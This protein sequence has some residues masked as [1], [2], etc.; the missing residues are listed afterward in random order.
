M[1]GRCDP[2]G[3]M[4]VVP[5]I[6]LVGKER[7]TRVESHPHPNLSICQRSLRVRGSRHRPRRTRECNEEC[8]PLRIDLD[9]LVPRPDVPQHAVM[10]GKHLGIPIAQPLKQPRR[11]LNIGE[12]KRHRPGRKLPLHPPI[13]YRQPARA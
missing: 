1:R 10:L 7:L 8:I 4:Y 3:S 11:A 6:P 5:D 13:L 9:P 2:R 12:Q